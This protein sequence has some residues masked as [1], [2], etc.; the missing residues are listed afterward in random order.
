MFKKITAM[1]LCMAL[2]AGCSAA[3]S[4][5]AASSQAAPADTLP[6][7]SYTYVNPDPNMVLVKSKDGDITYKDYRLYLDISEQFSRYTS[8][9]QL[10]ICYTIEK[11]MAEMGVEIDEKQY[12]EMAVGQID[13]LYNYYPTFKPD[14]LT[15]ADLAGITEQQAEE[16]VKTSFRMEYLIS[17]LGDHYQKLALEEM[18]EFDPASVTY[19]EN[20][21]NTREEIEAEQKMLH[22]QKVYEHAMEM[23]DQ[24]SSKYNDRINLDDEKFVAVIDGVEIPF[25]DRDNWFVNYNAASTRFDAA[26]IIQQGE[27]VLRD[28]AKTDKLPDKELFDADF[29]KYIESVRAEAA[30]I[31]KVEPYCEKLGATIDDYFLAFQRMSWLESVGSHYY[32]L[33]SESYAVEHPEGVASGEVAPD[34]VQPEVSF[35]EYC[36]AE[37]DKLFEGSEIVNIMG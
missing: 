29:G 6:E 26:A 7:G 9:Q 15:V 5:P 36:A 2:I 24:Y 4:Q 37:M 19:E 3:S 32:Q 27:L 1:L 34:A 33:L 22:D 30:Y 17:M 11:D 18:G 12:D 21:V 25:S 28:L 20:S 16:V 8:R 10:A 13:M 35:E 14:M 31:E 23:L